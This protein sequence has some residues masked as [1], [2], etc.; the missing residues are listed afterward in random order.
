MLFVKYSVY[1]FSRRVPS[2]L[3]FKELFESGRA[4]PCEQ[5]NLL[6]KAFHSLLN[7]IST[8]F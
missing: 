4:R 2:N 3:E 8:Q 1:L 5:S 7:I 6:C